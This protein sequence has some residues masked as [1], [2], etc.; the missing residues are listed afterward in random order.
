MSVTAAITP[1][2]SS[3]ADVAPSQDAGLPIRIAEATVFGL[4][5]GDPWT[6]GAAPSACAPTIRGSV[7]ARPAAWYC[8]NPFQ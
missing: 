1:P 3:R 7:V 8:R 2:D 4:A 6:I 5:T